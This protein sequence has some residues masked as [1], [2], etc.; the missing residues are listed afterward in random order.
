VTNQIFKF[1]LRA[2]LLEKFCELTGFTPAAIRQ[3]IHRGDWAEGIEFCYDPAHRIHVILEGYD[4]WVASGGALKRE[5]KV[6][7]SNLE[8]MVNVAAPH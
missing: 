2:L 7:L 3:K 1:P 4:R 6:A 8:D 5:S